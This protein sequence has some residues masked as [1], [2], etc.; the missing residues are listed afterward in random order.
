MVVSLLLWSE[1]LVVGWWW[2]RQAPLPLDEAQTGALSTCDDPGWIGLVRLLRQDL[3]TGCTTSRLSTLVATHLDG[4]RK[5]AWVRAIAED[6][7]VAP[8]S[9]LR[10][11]V[12]LL[13]AGAAPARDLSLLVTHPLVPEEDH[14]DIV[15]VCTAAS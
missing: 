5:E 8:R 9:R 4:P 7:V 6:P 3:D 14:A 13:A 15:D 10:A 12:A 1:L 11:G 2:E